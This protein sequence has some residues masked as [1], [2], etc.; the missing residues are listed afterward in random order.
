MR[1]HLPEIS[2]IWYN[3]QNLK[4]LKGFVHEYPNGGRGSGDDDDVG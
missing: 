4:E 1:T 2:A 3:L